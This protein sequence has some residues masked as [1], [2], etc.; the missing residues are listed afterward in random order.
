MPHNAT[1]AGT[2]LLVVCSAFVTSEDAMA[3]P[4]RQS[5]DAPS[6]AAGATFQYVYT[7]PI[8]TIRDQAFVA[9]DR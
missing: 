8:I 9:V 4:R 7:P 5:M 2:I 3:R 6:C 1:V